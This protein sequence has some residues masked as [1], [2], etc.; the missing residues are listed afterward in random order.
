M[1]ITVKDIQEKDFEILAANGYNPDQVD[2]FLDEIAA[3]LGA[4]QAENVSLKA[5]LEEIQKQLADALAEKTEIEKK[6]PDYNENGY[7]KN[8]ESAMRESL[9]GAQRIADQT[10]GEANKK[11]EQT[12]T[13]A[14]A[15]AEKTVAD[16]DAQA[17]QTIA[18][19]K[20]KAAHLVETAEKKVADLTAQA[21]EL[22][23]TAANYRAGF[24]K[25]V[26]DH[27]AV[28]DKYPEE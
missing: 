9:I 6:L 25:L 17:A 18:D 10:L 11:A 3:D 4:V 22:R 28:L 19:A 13:D 5:Q 7:F 14:N 1:A 23:S 27:L 2:D 16:A 24:K 20:A 15:K 21:E 8:L 12:I 26:E